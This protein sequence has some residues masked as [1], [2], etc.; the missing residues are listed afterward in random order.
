MRR[1]LLAGLLAL[2]LVLT[3][4]ADAAAQGCATGNCPPGFGGG[5]GPVRSNPWQCGIFCFKLFGALHQDGPLFN[6]GPYSGYYPFAPYGPWTADL[7]Y[8]GGGCG[9]CGLRGCGGRCG[10]GLNLGGLFHRDRGCNGCN[11]YSLSTFRNVFSRL[12]LFHKDCGHSGGCGVTTASCNG[13]V[14]ER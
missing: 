2:P 9:H 4:A 14:R 8:T 12:H 11:S 7:R 5:A 3:T 10:G 6:Y 13:C 1:M